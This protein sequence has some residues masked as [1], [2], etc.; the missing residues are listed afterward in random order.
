MRRKRAEIIVGYDGT[1]CKGA[2]SAYSIIYTHRLADQYTKESFEVSPQQNDHDIL[3]SGWWTLQHPIRYLNSGAQTDIVFN[4]P[5]CV[6]FTK[7]AMTEFS[8]GYDESVAYFGK[9]QKW[10]GVIGSLHMNEEE[11]V[12]L[13]MPR[14]ISCQYRDYMSVYN[15][16]HSDEI[17]P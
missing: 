11:N 14:E 5:K 8:I 3:M 2:G 16:Q 12:T 9:E 10:V 1:V 17:P 15:G 13:D 7:S 4:S 6:N